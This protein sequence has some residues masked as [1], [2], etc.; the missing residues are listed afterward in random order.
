[1]MR[2]SIRMETHRRCSFISSLKTHRIVL[3]YLNDTLHSRELLQNGCKDYRHMSPPPGNRDESFFPL[4][5]SY[6]KIYT[7]MQFTHSLSLLIYPKVESR[8]VSRPN[9]PPPSQQPSNPLISPPTHNNHL[10]PSRVG[11]VQL[12]F[13]CF[14]LLL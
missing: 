14:V 13:D 3:L 11:V 10:P 2:S 12:S 7:L 8:I 6:N 4:R 1:M 5:S 9:N